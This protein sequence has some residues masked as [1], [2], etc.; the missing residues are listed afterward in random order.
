MFIDLCTFTDVYDS[1]YVSPGQAR[2]QESIRAALDG[3]PHE[4][5]ITE[6]E[7]RPTFLV[8]DT[9]CFIDHLR[10]IRKLVEIGKY[11]LIVPLVG[12]YR[13]WNIIRCCFNCV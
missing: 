7:I 4:G 13:A 11:T 9:N 5:R 6:L 3:T 1:D 2:K 8:A 10:S 12:Q